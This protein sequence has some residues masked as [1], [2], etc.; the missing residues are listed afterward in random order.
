MEGSRRKTKSLHLCFFDLVFLK[1]GGEEIN[2]LRLIRGLTLTTLY[3]ISARKTHYLFLARATF[4]YLFFEV[5]YLLRA[6]TCEPGTNEK[7]QNARG[8]KIGI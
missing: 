5:I 4:T 6:E 7:R 3:K 2:P 8:R 1:H